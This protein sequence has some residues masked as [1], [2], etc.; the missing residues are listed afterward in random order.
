MNAITGQGIIFAILAT[1]LERPEGQLAMG[2]CALVLGAYGVWKER[3]SSEQLD[4]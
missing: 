2:I 3:Y 1:T 4:R